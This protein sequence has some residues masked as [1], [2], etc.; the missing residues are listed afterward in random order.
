M[1][2]SELLAKVLLSSDFEDFKQCMFDNPTTLRFDDSTSTSRTCQEPACGK[3]VLFKPEADEASWVSQLRNNGFS[4]YL[5]CGNGHTHRYWV[6]VSD[7]KK[8]G[9]EIQEIELTLQ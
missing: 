5:T 8:N 4:I 9:D 3:E 1:L 2:I 7:W 6:K